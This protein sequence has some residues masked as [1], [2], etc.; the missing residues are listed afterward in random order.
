MPL[1]SFLLY[2][3]WIYTPLVF[4]SVAPVSTAMRFGYFVARWADVHLVRFFIGSPIVKHRWIVREQQQPGSVIGPHK[5]EIVKRTLASL[6]IEIFRSSGLIP[7][8]QETRRS[9]PNSRCAIRCPEDERD[10]S[11]RLSSCIRRLLSHGFSAEGASPKLQ[12]ELEQVL[13]QQKVGSEGMPRSSA[14]SLS[15]W[16]NS[17]T[18]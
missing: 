6:S 12:N 9:R 8:R 1:S 16:R 14:F 3:P 2:S 11:E 7:D 4:G 15:C 5:G 13:S 18:C 17:M 10:S